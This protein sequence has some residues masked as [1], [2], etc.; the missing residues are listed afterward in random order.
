MERKTEQSKEIQA[1]GLEE[2]SETELLEG[3]LEI[4]SLPG[5]MSGTQR[6]LLFIINDE[7]KRRRSYG[8][9]NSLPPA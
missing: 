9:T 4:L 6:R 2:R 8:G 3:V 7:L 1:L 5:E